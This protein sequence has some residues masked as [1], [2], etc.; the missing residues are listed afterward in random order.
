M[1]ERV[2]YVQGHSIAITSYGN[3]GIHSNDGIKVGLPNK[4][5]L[6]VLTCI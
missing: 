1:S 5:G 3:T 4:Y 2:G 6:V